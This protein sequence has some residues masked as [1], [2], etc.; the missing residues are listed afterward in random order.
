VHLRTPKLGV[1]RSAAGGLS[2]KT[3]K[4]SF[5]PGALLQT[6]AGFLL[7]ESLFSARRWP[8]A[9]D[10]IEQELAEFHG[11]PVFPISQKRVRRTFGVEAIEAT[12]SKVAKLPASYVI[13]QE[14]GASDHN[15]FGAIE[16]SSVRLG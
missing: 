2:L 11:R 8:V 1:A 12:F 4:S 3:V 5:Q 13:S 7:S 16:P 6:A 9:A 10:L 15:S 14:L